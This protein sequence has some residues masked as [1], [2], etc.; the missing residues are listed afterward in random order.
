MDLFKYT[1]HELHEKLVNK[2]ITAVELTNCVYDRIAEVDEQVNAYIS[3]SKEEALAQAAEVDAKIAAGEAIAPLAGIP[4]VFKDN[5]NINGQV[6]SCASK[7]LNGVKAIFDAQATENLR[8]ENA[9]FLGKA[10]MAEFSIGNT[11]EN[12]FFGAAHNPWNLNCT[13]GGC[14]TAA[15]VAAGEAIWALASDTSGDLRQPAAYAGCVGIKPT[16]GRVSRLGLAAYASSMDQI[17]AVTKDVTDAATVLNV[18]CGKD[19]RDSTSWEVETPDFTKALVADVKGLRIG[20]PQEYFGENVDAKIKAEVEKAI[21]QYK[22]MGAEIV[23]VS[24]PHTQYAVRTFYVIAN[25][26][27][28]ANF[29]RYD[30]VRYGYR[31]MEAQSASEMTARSRDEGFGE[32][33]KLRLMFGTHVLSKG[34]YEDYYVR[35]MKV[36]TLIRNDF[37]EAFKQCDVLLTPTTPVLAEA[38]NT[39]MDAFAKYE[40]DFTTVTANLAG[41]PAITVPC[42]MVDGMPVGMQLIGKV[43][44]EATILKAAYTFEQATD[45]HKAMA[46]LG[47]NK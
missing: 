43:L 39:E 37:E 27:A 28:G 7:M 26:E 41:L 30:G 12:S 13:T 34:Y 9:V 33:V 16:Y 8:K 38:Y 45:F 18:I 2:E 10:N 20:V 44:D 31:N 25:G 40:L 23:E 1:A 14:A 17:G 19:F 21:E 32:E 4:V 47:G 3:L 6:T 24:M 15:A 42:G 11:T 46:P 29:A 35:A 22:A 5:I 36:R